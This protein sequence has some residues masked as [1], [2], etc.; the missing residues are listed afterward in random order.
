MATATPPFAVPSSFVSTMPFTPAAPMNSRACT[1]PF[2]PTV[3]SITRSTSCGAPGTSR[4]AMRRIFS[5]SFIRL[6]RVC[7]R[8]AVSTRIG[9]RP[10]A[11]PDEIAETLPVPAARLDG[12]D[13]TA[14][15]GN[16]DIGGDQQLFERVDR[17]DVDRPRP[18]LGLVGEAHELLEAVGDLLLGA[19][20]TFADA[21]KNAH[22]RDLTITPSPPRLAGVSASARR[23]RNGHPI[24]RQARR[25]SAPRS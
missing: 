24:G 19:R 20:E 11:L 5:S 23:R 1:T 9:S 14:G 4:A 2:W 18:P 13:D 8:P 10:F 15:G 7:R 17:V 12:G 22:L 16:A 25:P 3:A 6:T 21:S